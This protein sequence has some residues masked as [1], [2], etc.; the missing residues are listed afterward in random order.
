[1]PVFVNPHPATRHCALSFNFC[2]V[3][4]IWI[5]WIL[6]P[7]RA[8]FTNCTCRKNARNKMAVFW[9][10]T[11]LDKSSTYFEQHDVIAMYW[12]SILRMFASS[13]AVPHGSI[14]RLEIVGAENN[15]QIPEWSKLERSCDRVTKWSWGDAVYL[16]VA[17]VCSSQ[18]KVWAD[19]EPST[20][21][22]TIILY[23]GHVQQF[24]V[25]NVFTIYDCTSK[26]CWGEKWW[27]WS[28]IFTPDRYFI[29][30][31]RSKAQEQVE[32]EKPKNR[33]HGAIAG[34]MSWVISQQVYILGCVRSLHLWFWTLHLC[35][36]WGSVQP[37][38]QKW[39]SQ[40]LSISH[41]AD[42][43]SLS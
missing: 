31:V 12:L 15:T 37:T 6:F 33:M 14:N 42:F 4:G 1:M 3:F 17:T 32:T 29:L 13:D 8:F 38:W 26:C 27:E 23:W 36:L 43:P 20:F 28:N 2:A 9:F 34:W 24:L 7:T 40:Q 30:T 18:H 25:W 11:R 35:F 21:V 16:L 39:M 10:L 19:E 22:L 41:D 5:G